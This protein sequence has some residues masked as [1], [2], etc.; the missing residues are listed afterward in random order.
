MT[1]SH[2]PPARPPRPHRV[3]PLALLLLAIMRGWQV[4]PRIDPQRC[5]FYPSCSAYGITA[6]GRHGALRGGW[7]AVRRLGR[8]HPWNPGGVDHVPSRADAAPHH[9][10][11]AATTTEGR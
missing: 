9:G 6:V 11:G 4:L 7:M 5:R 10:G 3:T 1:A 2:A 8:C